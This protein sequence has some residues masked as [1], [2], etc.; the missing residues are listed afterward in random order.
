M[1]VLLRSLTRILKLMVPDPFRKL[2][3]DTLMNIEGD[4]PLTLT[5]CVPFKNSFFAFIIVV[6]TYTLRAPFYYG[7]Y[8]F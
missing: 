5:R 1:Y 4:R 8:R 2:K 3:I 7:K 6:H